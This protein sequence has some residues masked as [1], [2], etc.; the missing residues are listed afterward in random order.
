MSI[1]KRLA[2]LVAVTLLGLVGTGIYGA[3]Q[4]K[5]LQS[6]FNEVNE[7][8]VPSLIA[9][10]NVNDQFK[11]A[12]ALILALLMEEDADL[13][14]AF[15]DKIRE[16][17]R[18]LE[19]ATTA[20]AQI[21]GSEEAAKALIPIVA[22]YMKAVDVV[23]GV[24]DKKDQAQVELYTKVIP[25]E[26]VLATFLGKTRA[27]LLDTQKALKEQVDSNAQRSITVFLVVTAVTVAIVAALG[28]LLHLSVTRALHSM[29]MAMQNVASN[30]DFRLR[31]KV[32]QEDEIGTVIGVFNSLLDTVQT[33]LKEIV[34]SMDVLTN[35]TT[36]LSNSSQDIRKISEQTSASSSE[37]SDTVKR[38]NTSIE[39]VAAQT[40][41]A[42]SITRESEERAIAGGKVIQETIDHVKSIS[43][44]VHQ[45][46]DDISELR[47][48]ISSISTVVKVIS[49]VADQT[50]LLALNAAIE[51]ARAGEQGRG[52]AV[53]ADEVRKLAETTAKSTQEI[54]KVIK[55]VQQSATSTVE[56][57]E[58]AVTRVEGGVTSSN[59]AIEAL[60]AIRADTDNVRNTVSNIA[61]SIREQS[62]AT[63]HMSV[64]IQKIAGTTQEASEAV[65]ETTRSTQE[66]EMLA[67]RV[68]STVKRYQ[69]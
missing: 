42:E 2:I 19:K 7:R 55:S 29:T 63:S 51:A 39:T 66:L 37:A 27:Q 52:F 58:V 61:A 12:R 34:G 36:R 17:E 44:I 18:E 23:I 64:Q 8:S 33:S 13:R 59:H 6:S 35:A 32:D 21:P 25:A 62:V 54:S 40:E 50:N 5:G 48:Q 20:F 10:S 69:I 26:K 46:A 57:M 24:A 67:A 15:A 43:E 60:K 53:V 11:E 28:V 49:E 65:G 45:A 14:K 31:V 4:L 22:S 38:V 56:R 68:N 16:T 41:H 30:L 3:L 9:T 47:T 1:G